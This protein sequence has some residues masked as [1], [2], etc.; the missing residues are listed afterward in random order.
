MISQ[1][2]PNP[3]CH[4][5]DDVCCCELVGRTAYIDHVP[6]SHYLQKQIDDGFLTV[7]LLWD[8]DRQEVGYLLHH[9]ARRLNRRH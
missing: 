4:L 7:Q 1:F 3:Y 6:S 2:H 8:K 5:V 9:V